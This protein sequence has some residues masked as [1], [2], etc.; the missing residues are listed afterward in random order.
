MTLLVCTFN[1][2]DDL[3][4][5]LQTALVQKTGGEFAYEVLVVDNNS[6]DDTRGV[7]EELI[8]RGHANLRYLFEGRQGKS[9]ALNTGL[10]HV[11]GWAYTICDDDF[12]LPEDWLKK[13]F[14]AFHSHPE[15]SFISGK[16]LPAWGATGTPPA[17]LTSRHWSAIA[18]TDYGDKEFYADANNQICLL[19]C[20][21]RTGE[22]KAVGGYHSELGVTKN[23]IGGTEDFE[24]LQRLWK[25]GRKGIYLPHIWFHH[26][27]TPDRLTKQYHRRWHTGHGRFYAAMRDEGF[28]RASARLFDVPAHMFKQAGKDALL[29][30]RSS[31]ARRE[32]EAFWHE[33]RLRFFA[34]FLGKRREDYSTANRQGGTTREVFSF[35]RSIANRKSA[36]VS[37]KTV[38]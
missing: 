3:R 11:S 35:L 38:R 27:V 24:I 22:V 14:A 25:S 13:I 20:S 19:A 17:W 34:G 1:R 12:L 37:Q 9:H 32:D 33:T 8:R 31:L 26:K 4:E 29:W 7:V 6:S 30:L 23:Q 36:R 18:M 28:E 10:S 15:A 16:V 5:M 2:S 21:F